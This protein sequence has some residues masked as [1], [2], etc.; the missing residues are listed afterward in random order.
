M[1]EFCLWNGGGQDY[2]SRPGVWRCP[3]FAIRV[4]PVGISLEQAFARVTL[5]VKVRTSASSSSS[6]AV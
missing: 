3:A 6:S 1:M 4:R 2:E 5:I